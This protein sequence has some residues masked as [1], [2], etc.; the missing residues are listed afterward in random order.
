MRDVR[1]CPCV[2]YLWND[3]IVYIDIIVIKVVVLVADV[4]YLSF[5]PDNIVLVLRGS[6]A[7]VSRKTTAV[8]GFFFKFYFSSFKAVESIWRELSD[9]YPPLHESATI[10]P[11][12]PNHRSWQQF[13]T[14]IG[15]RRKGKKGTIEYRKWCFIGSAIIYDSLCSRIIQSSEKKIMTLLLR[16]IDEENFKTM[17]P[18]ND[19]WYDDDTDS[20]LDHQWQS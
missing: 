14:C 20:M 17:N 19:K 3:R 1:V 9:A 13:A 18:V 7:T 2:L 15:R 8:G 5:C 16:R 12:P 4:K 6:S 11:H 10:I